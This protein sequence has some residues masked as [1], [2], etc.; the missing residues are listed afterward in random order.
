M[1]DVLTELLPLG[2]FLL[3]MP[4]RS[5]LVIFEVWVFRL[6]SRQRVHELCPSRR[7]CEKL[8]LRDQCSIEQLLDAIILKM[9]SNQNEFLSSVSK[10][11]LPKFFK[12]VDH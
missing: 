9:P 12:A 7:T 8:V 1:E 4:S 11:Q 6:P 2:Q 5:F 3:Q 10:G